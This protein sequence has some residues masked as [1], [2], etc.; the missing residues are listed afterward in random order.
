MLPAPSDLDRWRRDLYAVCGAPNEFVSHLEPVWHGEP[1]VCRIV[2]Y[3]VIPAR[4]CSPLFWGADQRETLRDGY[5]APDPR[6][7]LALNP[8]A[9]TWRQ[10]QLYERFGTI[11]QPFW[12]VQGPHGGHKRQF[13]PVERRLL[14]GMGLPADPPLAGDLPYA[15]LD[16][17]VLDAIRPLDVM[18]M[19]AKASA[20]YE[21]TPADFDR[22]ERDALQRGS[23]QL[24]QWLS[25]QMAHAFDDVLTY[26]KTVADVFDR[27]GDADVWADIDA[28]EAAIEAQYATP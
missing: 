3:Q 20:L 4:G 22:E 17:R 8:E 6:F 14:T 5:P 2:L 7:R 10:W 19:W 27:V 13:N 12:I 18:Q 23:R 11:A 26:R 24:N 1:E 15:P 16:S 25:T 9:L 21:R 28:T